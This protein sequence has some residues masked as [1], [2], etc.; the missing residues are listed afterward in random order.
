MFE[1]FAG[2][3]R[4]VVEDALT[5]AERRGAV[6]I[7]SDHLL[8]ALLRNEEIAAAAGTDAAAVQMAADQLDRDALAAIGVSVSEVQLPPSTVKGKRATRMTSGAK[9]VLKGTLGYAAAEKSPTIAPRHML[10]ALLDRKEPDPAAVLLAA[11]PVDRG[12]LRE[13]LARAA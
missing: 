2:E 6:R 9:E 8:L 10:L 13:R 12:E 7:A 11:L 5:E 3:A 4:A 1:R